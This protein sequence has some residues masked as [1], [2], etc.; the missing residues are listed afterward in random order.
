MFR[1]NGQRAAIDR[2]SPDPGFGTSGAQ[3]EA[4]KPDG[5]TMI[6]GRPVQLRFDAPLLL[7]VIV[8][9]VFG[10]MMVFSSSYYVSI[11]VNQGDPFAIVQRQ[12][13]IMLLG[14]AGMTVAAFIP[15]RFYQRLAV[16]MMAFTL[17]VLVVVLVINRTN[18]YRREL[19]GDS[20]QPSELAKLVLIIYLAI[21]LFAKRERL[22]TFSLGFIPMAVMLGILGGLI[23]GQPDLSAVITLVVLGVL[24]F[25]LAG[26]DL[27]QLIFLG[28]VALVIGFIVFQISTTASSRVG[29]FLAGLKDPFGAPDQVQRSIESFING[30]WFGVGIGNGE[31]KVTG[32]Q[33]PHTDSIFAVVG[34]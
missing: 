33:F 1:K 7:I 34:E 6:A 5:R 31:M 19:I 12:F 28:M 20:V 17:L 9:L 26:G 3:S 16:P 32:L 4:G 24:M 14:V 13:L 2:R 15:Y 11:K 22:H 29:G 25:F 18:F 8:L 10:I 27:K 30:G 23:A 21:W